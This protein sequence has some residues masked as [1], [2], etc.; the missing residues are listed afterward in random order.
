MTWKLFA[1]MKRLVI[2]NGLS[3]ATASFLETKP[4][5]INV[6]APLLCSRRISSSSSGIFEYRINKIVADH[7]KYCVHLSGRE[8]KGNI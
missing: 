6:G 3:V 2:D 1:K 8:K 7:Y 5:P 4:L